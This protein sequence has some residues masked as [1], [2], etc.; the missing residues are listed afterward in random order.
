MYRATARGGRVW[1]RKEDRVTKLQEHIK[2]EIRSLGIK[3]PRD[4]YCYI[5]SVAFCSGKYDW[6]I[7]DGTKLRMYD[8]T[9]IFKV[10]EDGISEGLGIDDS[11]SVHNN[12]SKCV[13]P[14]EVKGHYIAV[15]LT[16]YKLR[17][18]VAYGK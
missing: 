10:V 5:S 11:L 3:I 6:I 9:N 13:L 1:V 17:R 15:L 16:F 8:L 2:N 18:E 14:N 12:Q 7:N 4:I